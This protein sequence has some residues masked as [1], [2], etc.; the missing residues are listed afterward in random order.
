MRY[1]PRGAVA[2]YVDADSISC[3]R[4]VLDSSSSIRIVIDDSYREALGDGIR[5]LRAS[6]SHVVLMSF[7][8]LRELGGAN[9][10][11]LNASGADDVRAIFYTSG[12]TGTPKG[13]PMKHKA[14]VA[15][16][17]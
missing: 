2:I 17:Q 6:F 14:V 1:S 7:D 13:V 16:G 3:L 10:A 5:D 15:A 9:P 8:E 4:S 12:S 11:K